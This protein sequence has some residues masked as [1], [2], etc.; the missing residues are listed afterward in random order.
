MELQWLG[1]PKNVA[2]MPNLDRYFIH[3]ACG[4]L[5]FERIFAFET[6]SQFIPF[7]R[8]PTSEFPERDPLTKGLTEETSQF[9]VRKSMNTFTPHEINNFGF[10]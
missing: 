8:S 6:I 9:V 2:F 10:V 7:G 1:A 3:G 5:S 4:F